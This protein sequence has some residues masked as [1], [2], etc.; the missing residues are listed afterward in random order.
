M[1]LGRRIDVLGV[2]TF[3]LVI[4]L[5][6]HRAGT[7]FQNNLPSFALGDLEHRQGESFLQEAD[8]EEGVARASGPTIVHSGGKLLP[9]SAFTGPLPRFRERLVTHRGTQEPPLAFGNNGSLFYASF[10]NASLPEQEAVLFRSDD[11]GQTWVEN[12][13]KTSAGVPF[14]D[15]GI[16]PYLWRDDAS[17]R[18]FYV[19]YSR[20]ACSSI[21]WT[22]DNGASW[23]SSV[24]PKICSET[25]TDYPK[26]WTSPVAG[27]GTTPAGHPYFVH[28]CYNGGLT[29]GCQRSI[30]GGRTWLPASSPYPDT[31]ECDTPSPIPGWPTVHQ[32][33][34]TIYMPK[35]FCGKLEVAISR[36]NGDSWNRVVVAK[37]PHESPY[38]A[39]A[40]I[41]I[42]RAG[43]LYYM[44]HGAGKDVLGGNRV[45]LSVSRDKGRTWSSPIDVGIPGV[46]AV[47]YP[48]LVAGDD[49][50]IAFLYM[51][52][53]VRGGFNAPKKRMKQATWNAYV[54]FTLDALAYKP[55]I[56][57]AMINPPSDPLHMG[58]CDYRCSPDPDN[59]GT[60]GCDMG[61]PV[62][63]IFDYL[64]L[65][66]DPKTGRVAA[67]L[68]DQCS[69]ACAV[70][71]SQ[72]WGGWW[73]GAV[74]I[75]VAG[76][77]LLKP[78]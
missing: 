47:K 14:Q 67:S 54:G 37:D 11:F 16:D 59:C 6:P 21:A 72:D 29:L 42:D 1:R 70:G 53:D 60:V 65:A 51:G 22:D 9:K 32:R 7:T 71:R 10:G 49:G 44:W 66:L 64:Q 56:A 38:G 39:W 15:E 55:T 13:P 26:L 31:G 25:V 57:T 48:S 62:A 40:R 45:L 18:L 78:S 43:N 24:P 46:T 61:S 4:A 23:E 52:S 36:D 28:L 50:R 76:P 20:P 33:S 34:G 27:G 3:A 41:A 12:V 74:G 2:C 8:D 73:F 19:L 77:R 69:G 58:P 68:V 63:G 35:S 17:G 5:I 30:D 75:Q